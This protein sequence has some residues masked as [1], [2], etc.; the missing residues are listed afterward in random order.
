MATAT[1]MT[2]TEIMSTSQVAPQTSMQPQPGWRWQHQAFRAMNTDVL[3]WLYS[4]NATAIGHVP[5]TFSRIER[6]LSR[7]DANSELSQLNRCPAERFQASPELFE[8]VQ[9]ALWAAQA[10]DGIYDPT[11]LDSLER[12]GYDRSFERI[13]SPASYQLDGTENARQDAAGPRPF[14]HQDIALN[15]FTREISKPPGLRLDLGGMGK[16]WAVD[17][18]AD[19]LLGA[20]PFLVNA[21]GDLF[22][23]GAPD[24][25]QGWPIDLVHPLRVQHF[26]AGL[27]LKDRALATSTIVKR[28]WNK[29]GRLMHHL[30]DPRSGQPANTDALSVSVIAQRT[31]LAEIYAKAALILG[32]EAG[33]DYLQALPGVEGL[34]F[35]ANADMLYT[36]GMTAVLERIAP[37]GY[38]N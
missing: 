23:Y 13:A 19:R 18:A 14:S 37:D 10:T 33:L 17:R 26:M 15:V 2:T 9:T 1:N 32:V 36:S 5:A 16:G 8:A 24:D 38:L 12:A 31:L 20:G 3:A 22:A 4:R 34:I 35:T 6:R 30:I 29:N 27:R 25:G 7:F 11:I 21:G 28:R